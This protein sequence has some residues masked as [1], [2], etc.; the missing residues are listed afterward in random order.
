MKIRIWPGVELTV[1]KKQH[2]EAVQVSIPNTVMRGPV[3]RVL[4]KRGWM[5][6]LVRYD[7]KKSGRYYQPA[8]VRE[9]R[10]RPAHPDGTPYR[11]AEMVAEGWEFCDGCRMWSTATA[12]RPHQCEGPHMV[13]ARVSDEVLDGI[14]D[15]VRRGD[16]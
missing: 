13:V 3:R 11:Y 15:E 4:S 7:W 5:L 10:Q 6:L 14:V 2:P 1:W 8:A 12:E 16:R 9:Q